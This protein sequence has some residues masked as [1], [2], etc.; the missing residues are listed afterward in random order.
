MV[1]ISILLRNIKDNWS[2]NDEKIIILSVEH[3]I[4]KN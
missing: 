1:R 3:L 4:S 2:A